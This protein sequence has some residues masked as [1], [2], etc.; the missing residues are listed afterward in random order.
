VIVNDAIK[1][2]QLLV[3]TYPANGLLELGDEDAEHV[4]Q[5]FSVTE[6]D[7]DSRGRVKYVQ[8]ELEWWED[9]LEDAEADDSDDSDEEEEP[10]RRDRFT[11]D[12]D[13]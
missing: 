1:A 13:E 7:F 5:A 6:A 4:V 11:D 2:L 9:V 10:I 8:F 3:A 12:S